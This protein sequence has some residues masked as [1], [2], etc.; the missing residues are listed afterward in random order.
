MLQ[1]SITDVL[2]VDSKTSSFQPVQILHMQ[3]E[4]SFSL[5]SLRLRFA[6]H[7]PSLWRVI[8]LE[9]LTNVVGKRKLNFDENRIL[10]SLLPWKQKPSWSYLRHTQALKCQTPHS[11]LQHALFPRHTYPGLMA[12]NQAQGFQTNPSI[13]AMQRKTCTTFDQLNHGWF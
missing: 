2:S 12:Q 8:W 11:Y 3:G 7:H 9:V 6:K 10:L 5:H 4:V 13:S 1:S